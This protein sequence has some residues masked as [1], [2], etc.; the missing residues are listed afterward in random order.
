MP[1]MGEE[2]YEVGPVSPKWNA[3]SLNPRCRVCRRAARFRYMY[4]RIYAL[5]L[6]QTFN[7]LLC[8]DE[9]MHASHAGC[10]SEACVSAKVHAPGADHPYILVSKTPV[11]QQL[12]V[13]ALYSVMHE[14]DV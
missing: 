14:A 11:G 9:C 6:F 2:E 5:G 13:G 7:I 4:Q 3:Q 1:H 10:T 12:V 8:S